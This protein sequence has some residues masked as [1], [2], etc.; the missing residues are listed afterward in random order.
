MFSGLP[1]KISIFSPDVGT[2]YALYRQVTPMILVVDDDPSI[3][4]LCS[5]M[6]ERLDL[7][8]STVSCGSSARQQELDP[9]TAV[10]LDVQL[11]DESG[12]NLA[13]WFYEQK[14]SLPI[15]FF[16]GHSLSA[17]QLATPGQKVS[18][19]QKPFKRNELSEKLRELGVSC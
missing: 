2:A 15:L 1:G 7:A 19:L 12:A 6:L 10:L 3:Q 5:R 9:I 16:S 18:F 8:C 17:E 11:P 14:P 4:R 13:T